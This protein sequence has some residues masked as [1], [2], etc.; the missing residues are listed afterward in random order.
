M[1][2]GNMPYSGNQI[3]ENYLADY[4]DIFENQNK[5]SISAIL[6]AK[7]EHIVRE[8]PLHHVLDHLTANAV[9]AMSGLVGDVETILGYW[10][11]S[12]PFNLIY[13]AKDLSDKTLITVEDDGAGINPAIVYAAAVAYLAQHGQIPNWDIRKNPEKALEYVFR[14]SLSTKGSSGAGLSVSEVFM[15]DLGKIY[16]LGTTYSDDRRLHT[17]GK[18]HGKTTGSIMA[19]EIPYKQ[20]RDKEKMWED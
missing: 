9:E 2:A 14:D 8:L 3:I 12:R 13:S 18:H 11:P 19:I 16:V 15:K 1:Q 6:D 4:A 10:N 20:T 5:I 7:K 17:V